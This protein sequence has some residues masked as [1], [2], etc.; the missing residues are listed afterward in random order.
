MPKAKGPLNR[1]SRKSLQQQIEE[2]VELARKG[3]FLPKTSTSIRFGPIL[4]DALMAYC[5]KEGQQLS[6]VIE[7]AVEEFLE[8]RK[9]WVRD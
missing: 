6:D 5:K 1:R 8:R 3:K 2:Q 4:R 7:Q 9:A